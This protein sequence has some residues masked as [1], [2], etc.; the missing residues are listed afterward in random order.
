M[1]KKIF[2][3]Y[4]YNAQH[5]INKTNVFFLKFYK[6]VTHLHEHARTHVIFINIKSEFNQLKSHLHKYNFHLFINEFFQL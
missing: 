3:I 5:L 2:V 1:N 6:N 4:K